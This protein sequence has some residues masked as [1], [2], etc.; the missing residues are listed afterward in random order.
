LGQWLPANQAIAQT[1]AL[2]AATSDRD[3][4]PVLAAILTQQGKL[5]LAQ[6]QA[7][8]ALATWQ[9]AE[10]IYR[11]LQD[12]SGIFGS[13]INQARVLQAEGFD[14]RATALL[15]QVTAF[16]QDQPDSPLKMTGLRNLG[17]ALR[18]GGNLAQ[19]RTV[20]EQSLA[21]ALKFS[22]QTPRSA[23]DISGIRFSLGN[24]ARA[25]GDTQAALA[26]Y[27]QAVASALTLTA[28]TQIQLGQLSLLIE[29]N[30][31]TSQLTG[32][33][34]E[35]QRL[36]IDLRS[37]IPQLPP[38][39]LA[40]YARIHF[41]QT[42]IRLKGKGGVPPAA[43]LSQA[44]QD[45]ATTVLQMRELGDRRA[46][47]YA[48]GTLGGLYEMGRG[49]NRDPTGPALGTVDACCRYYLPVAV[50]TGPDFLPR[51]LYCDC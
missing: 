6:G 26:F 28:K 8:D 1:N 10:S 11:Q 37:H 18:L 16:L 14:R 2:L 40:A 22:D 19:S 46:A 4:L 12:T 9:Q 21:I 39:R 41:A 49:R 36:L 15:T 30:P 50:A 32:Q 33:L 20:L 38:G 45:L 27:Q 29:T 35:I 24:T 5:Q 31:L 34:P 7:T 47:S 43:F 51:R 17:K 42:L 48:L 23:A 44:A 3:R 25:Q 13:Q